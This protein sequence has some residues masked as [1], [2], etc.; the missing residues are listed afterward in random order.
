MRQLIEKRMDGNRVNVAV[1]NDELVEMI[2]LLKSARA[3][4]KDGKINDTLLG[5]A[6]AIARAGQ[7]LKSF[8]V[9]ELKGIDRKI[10]AAAKE[11]AD[12]A[13]VPDGPGVDSQYAMRS[14]R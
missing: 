13:H 1:V 11:I 7:S 8:R 12:V 5:M 3:D 10:H 14:V 2:N 9:K 4:L 6:D